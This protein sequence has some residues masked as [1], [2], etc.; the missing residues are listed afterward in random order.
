MSESVY[1]KAS[2]EWSILLRPCVLRRGRLVPSDDVLTLNL[3]EAVRKFAASGTRG[4]RANVL[5]ARSGNYLGVLT[6]RTSFLLVNRMPGGDIAWLLKKRPELET[7]ISEIYFV[8][9]VVIP[10]TVV[11]L[12]PIGTHSDLGV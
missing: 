10:R 11:D 12:P 7:E 9:D 4:A 8:Q 1:P 2:V 5:N 3:P 6:T